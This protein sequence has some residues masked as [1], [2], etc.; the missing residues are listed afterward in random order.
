MPVQ[1]FGDDC[2]LIF[3][4][5]DD[6]EMLLVILEAAANSKLFDGFEQDFA[7]ELWRELQERFSV[8]L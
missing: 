1:K 2:A 3:V 8:E 4:T 6:A 7:H 5:Q